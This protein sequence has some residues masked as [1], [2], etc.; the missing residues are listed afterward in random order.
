MLLAITGC[1]RLFLPVVRWAE[2]QIQHHNDIL[3]PGQSPEEFPAG[4]QPSAW[5]W[6]IMKA[7]MIPLSGRRA[8]LYLAAV[9]FGAASALYSIVWLYYVPQTTA[10]R[11]GAEFTYSLASHALRVTRVLPGQNAEQAGLSPGDEILAINNAKLDTLTP[12][13]EAVGRGKPGATVTFSVRRPGGASPRV[14]LVVLDSLPRPL[15]IYRHLTPGRMIAVRIMESYPFVFL[16]VGLAVLFLKIEDRNAWLLA[17]VFG[18]FV[19]LPDIPPGVIHP[20]FR[21][22]LMSYHVVL[23]DLLPALLYLFLAV[24]PAP[25]P[26]ERR[27]PW[28]KGVLLVGAGAFIA[29]DLWTIALANAYETIWLPLEYGGSTWFRPSIRALSYLYVLGGEGLAVASLI[30][31]SFRAVSAEAQRKAGVIVWGVACGLVPIILLVAVLYLTGRRFQDTPFW[32]YAFC[33]LALFL[34]PLSFAYAVVVHRVMEIPVLLK[35]SA[36]YLLVQRG[37]V[38]LILLVSWGASAAFVL[39]FTRLL[40]SRAEVALPLGL[41]AGVALGAVLTWGG[42]EAA[43]RG[44][45]RIDRAFFRNAYDARVILEELGEQVRTGKDRRS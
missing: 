35:R 24:F 10:T 32:L 41:G 27:V 25:S 29:R 18:G 16:V 12:Y 20:A 34:L 6:L 43:K 5:G 19:A 22:F 14:V 39:A 30:G 45:R 1:P 21:S 17:L 3:N 38:S 40:K 31:N 11:I 42:N 26:L 2:H 44:T 15:G 7:R 4:G 9:L 36:R 23:E 8:L 13:Y 33:V 37:F 28:L